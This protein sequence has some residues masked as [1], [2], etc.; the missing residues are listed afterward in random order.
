MKEEKE[1]VSIT[2][3]RE[4][5]ILSHLNHPNVLSLLEVLVTQ[6]L[7]TQRNIIYLVFDYLEHD[8]HGLLD[9]HMELTVPQIK[10][11]MR[12]IL[13]GVKYL[14]E[15]NIMHR[16][17]KG[18]N[19]LLDN[20][21]C[22]KLADFGLAKRLEHTKGNHTNRVVT[23]W[24]RSPELLLGSDRYNTAIDI[25]SVGC[26]FAELLT[27]RPLFPGNKEHRVLELIYEKCGTPTEKVWPGVTQLRNYKQLGPKKPQP[28][29]RLREY[30]AKYKK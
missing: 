23:L 10:C 14:H 9:S 1:G 24:Y 2:M 16:D 13:E 6:S 28:Y 11:I 22:V 8:L 17:I 4:I 21:G 3:L 18:A 26:C 19:I 29:N 5:R 20:D 15:H 12:Q 7:I 30:L 27:L 25:W